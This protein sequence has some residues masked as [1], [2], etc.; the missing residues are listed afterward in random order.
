MRGNCFGLSLAAL[1]LSVA[2]VGGCR[3]PDRLPTPTPLLPS[4]EAGQPELGPRQVADVKVAL[5]QTLEKRGQVAE[6]M[7]AYTEAL[8][9]D[10]SRADACLRQAVLSDQQGQFAESAELYNKALA[11][12]PGDPD[13]Y[14][15]MGY[16]LYLQ[17]RWAEA[18]MNLRQALAL[19]HDHRRAHNNLGLVL[20]HTD[21]P[22]EAMAE[23]RKAGCSETDARANL[24][25]ALAMDGRWPEA[26]QQ[27][28]DALAKDPSSAALQKEV[29]KL[30]ALVAWANRARDTG[31]SAGDTA[32]RAA[33]TNSPPDASRQPLTQAS[34]KPL[35][36][37]AA[38]PDSVRNTSAP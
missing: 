6:A 33:T 35:K 27:Y 31:A 4:A 29:V 8:K 30:D 3:Q 24:A 7:A 38:G 26:R 5:G 13:I 28:A 17:Q 12:R 32:P 23:F 2:G 10:P 18:E 9:A 21:R 37:G 16:S 34:W 36:G 25:F 19:R 15:D 20:A 22:E 14:C 11:L 1:L